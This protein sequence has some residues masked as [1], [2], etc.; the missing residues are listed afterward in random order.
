MSLNQSSATAIT[1]ECNFNLK[2]KLQKYERKLKGRDLQIQ[3]YKNRII[4][5]ENTIETLRKCLYALQSNFSKLQLEKTEIKRQYVNERREWIARI[6][7]LQIQNEEEEEEEKTVSLTQIEEEEEEEEKEVPLTQDSEI[8]N[9]I[10]LN[11][12]ESRSPTIQPNTQ[13]KEFE[14]TPDDMDRLHDGSDSD[15]NMEDDESI[16]DT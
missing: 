7:E 3:Q 6:R 15:Y 5:F 1:N 12:N 4:K 9:A 8:S 16:N 10:E 11:D 14:A 13:D 2:M